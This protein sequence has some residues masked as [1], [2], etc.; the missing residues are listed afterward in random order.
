MATPGRC[1]FAQ[2]YQQHPVAGRRAAFS[3]CNAG[4]RRMAPKRVAQTLVQM[5]STES[6]A[7]LPALWPLGGERAPQACRV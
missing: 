7:K 6:E 3:G 1:A 2:R 5:S 4:A